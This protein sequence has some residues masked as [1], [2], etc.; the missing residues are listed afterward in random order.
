MNDEAVTFY[1]QDEDRRRSV[2]VEID[3]SGVNRLL[4]DGR[5]PL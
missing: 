3:A 2:E 4:R 1:G 5:K